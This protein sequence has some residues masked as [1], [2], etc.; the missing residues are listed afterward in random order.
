[1]H[2]LRTFGIGTA[3]KRS[4]GIRVGTVRYLPRGV[5]KEEYAKRDLFD[6]WFPL[7]APS[8]ELIRRLKSSE[9]TTSRW[10]EFAKSYER[11]LMRN[12]DARQALVL[13]GELAKR[14]PIAIG[15]Y[16]ADESR[17]HRSV[18]RVLIS[19]AGGER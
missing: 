17:C 19:K 8:K 2:K 3:R 1:M 14:T 15:C 6:V 18:L 4:E 13:L 10:S 9:I 16:C 12:V 11:E 5:R 7:L